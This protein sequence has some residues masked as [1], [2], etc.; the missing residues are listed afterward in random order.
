M[1]FDSLWFI[2]FNNG[3]SFTPSTLI[4]MTVTSLLAK[5]EKFQIQKN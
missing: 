4:K 1:G 2:Q 5:F 3:F